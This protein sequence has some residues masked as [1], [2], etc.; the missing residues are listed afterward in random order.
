MSPTWNRL[1]GEL[2]AVG[3]TLTDSVFFGYHVGSSDSRDSVLVR[4]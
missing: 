4:D 3:S 2:F 1:V